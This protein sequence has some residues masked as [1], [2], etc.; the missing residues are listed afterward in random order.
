MNLK[1]SRNAWSFP[2]C[3]KEQCSPTPNRFLPVTAWLFEPNSCQRRWVA[4]ECLWLFVHDDEETLASSNKTQPLRSLLFTGLQWI[5]V[6]C[7]WQWPRPLIADRVPVVL[8]M[9]RPTEKTW[10]FI[11]PQLIEAKL[12][13]VQVW[14]LRARG[15]G[16]LLF[17]IGPVSIS[18]IVVRHIHARL[19]G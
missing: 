3:P 4:E 14:K 5:Y 12:L 18:D 19:L 6:H 15:A 7:P 2:V 8:V 11:S 9:L 13:N 16:L 1:D 10:E 17:D